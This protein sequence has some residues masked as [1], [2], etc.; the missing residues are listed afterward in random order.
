MTKIIDLL[1]NDVFY[2]DGEMNIVVRVWKDYDKPL[3]AKLDY[4]GYLLKFY[5]NPDEIVSYLKDSK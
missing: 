3:I 1:E 2:V 4:M 5:E